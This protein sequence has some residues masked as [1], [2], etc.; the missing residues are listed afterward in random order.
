MR[1]KRRR[2]S[3]VSERYAHVALIMP[4]SSA[5][6]HRKVLKIFH[7]TCSEAMNA[8]RPF[9][10]Q[11]GEDTAQAEREVGPAMELLF[12]AKRVGSNA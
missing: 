12:P 1:N 4:C 9:I 3:D 5:S 10:Q 11:Y 2:L 6:E 8:M 7:H